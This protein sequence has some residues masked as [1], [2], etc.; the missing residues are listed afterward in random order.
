MNSIVYTYFCYRFKSLL[1]NR[2]SYFRYIKGLLIIS[3]RWVALS[4]CSVIC[5]LFTPHILEE[6]H[7]FPCEVLIHKILDILLF[8]VGLVLVILAVLYLVVLNQFRGVFSIVLGVGV[9]LSA[10]SFLAL[11]G[12]GSVLPSSSS[13]FIVYF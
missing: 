13:C 2:Q 1:S 4:V 10:V 8:L 7:P 11:F 9:T 5:F 12:S 3:C 6:K